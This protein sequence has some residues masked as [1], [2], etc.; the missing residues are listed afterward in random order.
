LTPFIEKFENPFNEDF[1]VEEHEDYSSLWK[2]KDCVKT[3]TLGV[4][5]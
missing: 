5:R 4:C 2:F 3:W 1:I